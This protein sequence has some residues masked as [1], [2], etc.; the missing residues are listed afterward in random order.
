MP[1]EGDTLGEHSGREGDDWKCR[2]VL[3]RLK[4]GVAGIVSR[5][6]KLLLPGVCIVKPRLLGR[7]L[8]GVGGFTKDGELGA[9]VVV[10]TG[11]SL[12]V[13]AGKAA[14]DISRP[15]PKELEVFTAKFFKFLGFL[16]GVVGR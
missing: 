5:V 1:P 11:A 8:G 7:R 2:N 4:E 10:V 14:V 6:G 15:T 9:E 13:A 3:G 16:A 12:F